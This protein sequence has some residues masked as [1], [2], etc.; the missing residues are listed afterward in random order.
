MS[1]TIN[2]EA[3]FENST[4]LTVENFS[5]EFLITT[6]EFNYWFNEEIDLEDFEEWDTNDELIPMTDERIED[7]KIDLVDDFKSSQYFD[8]LVENYYPMVSDLEILQN[9]PSNEDIRIV[10]ELCPNVT[11]LELHELGTCAL[12]LNGAGMN[13]SDILALSYWIIDGFSPIEVRQCL[14]LSKNAEE[15]LRWF[16]K[17]YKEKGFIPQD[18]RDNKIKQ[19]GLL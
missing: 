11:V 6:D 4:N 2:Y 18:K 7:I 17:T 19:L 15:L 10:T 8:D 3:N 1:Y 13:M 12:G 9:I 14:S 5:D 16:E